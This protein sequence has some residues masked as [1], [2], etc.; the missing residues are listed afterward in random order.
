MN[1][2]RIHRTVSADGTRIA[3]RVVGEGPAMVLVHGG[4]GHGE[5]PQKGQRGGGVQHDLDSLWRR[6]RQLT[7]TRKICGLGAKNG[8]RAKRLTLNVFPRRAMAK[9]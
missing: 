4:I 1:E 9:G 6:P 7:A 5:R 8:R 2:K 3:G